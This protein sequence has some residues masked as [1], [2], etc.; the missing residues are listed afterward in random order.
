MRNIMATI[1]ALG[2]GISLLWWGTDG[3]QAFTSEA[4][5]RLEVL[6]E[7]KALPS[8]RLED[9]KG[10]SFYL[11]DYRGKL[12]LATFIY[13]RCGDVCPIVEMN[14]RRVYETIRDE[15][16]GKNIVFLSISF[17]PEHDTPHVLHEHAEHYQADGTRWRVARVPN[18]KEL[19]I[20]LKTMG[21][22]VIPNGA[23]G[24]EHNAAFYLIDKQGRLVKIFD[25]NAPKVVGAEINRLIA[26][27]A[28]IL[29]RSE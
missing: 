1:L 25:Y 28:L 27:N 4:A 10:Q 20:L 29:K 15:Y 13:T 23:G 11:H 21:V 26:A 3:F 18:P 7:P 24:Y 6:K 17:D 8:V 19:N 16:L 5:R 2:L 9:Q 12:V 22:I 14:F